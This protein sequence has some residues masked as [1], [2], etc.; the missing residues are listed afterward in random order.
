MS[1]V[2]L[3]V[4]KMIMCAL[5]I[6]GKHEHRLC[7]HDCSIVSSTS[8]DSDYCHKAHL[9]MQL[10][11]N[12][13]CDKMS[14]VM[15]MEMSK[16]VGRF[17]FFYYH[18]IGDPTGRIGNEQNQLSVVFYQPLF[19]HLV[20]AVVVIVGNCA[21]S[22]SSSSPNSSTVDVGTRYRCNYD[23]KMTSLC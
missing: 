10:N 23:D 5:M 2:P 22:S 20:L 12:F 11:Y 3:G 4:P 17:P 19:L 7:H 6:S 15:I 8:P 9:I 13:P 21:S 14:L 18:I 16:L 1:C